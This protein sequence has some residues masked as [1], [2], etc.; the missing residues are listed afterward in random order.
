MAKEKTTYLSIWSNLG[1]RFLNIQK[2]IFKMNSE[3]T[4][5]IR[6]SS[7]YENAAVGF[8]G[9]DFLNACFSVSTQLAPEALLDKI[10]KIENEFG[11][12]RSPNAGYVSRP[13]DLDILY[14]KDKVVATEHLKVPHPRMTERNFVLKPLAD[15]APQY[16]H[17]VLKKDTRNLLQQC[18]DGNPLNKTK[19][20]LHTSRESLYG[21][22]QFLSIE[23]NIGAGKTTLTKMIAEDFN[24]K[25]V[26]ERFADNPFLPK[27]Y[28]DQSRYAFPLEMSFLAD[29]YQQFTDDTSQFDLFKKFMVSDYDIF[30]SLIFAKV[31]LQKEEFSLYKKVFN[32]MYKEVKKPDIYVYLYQSTQ[33]LLY[34]IKKRGRD[35]EQGI[36]A[37][38]LDKINRGYLDFIK[39]HPQ[40][41]TLMIDLA[42]LDFVANKTDYEY[43]MERIDT[44]LIET[45]CYDNF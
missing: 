14:F 24:A 12:E 21:Q 8:D 34:N 23:G 27:F 32:F 41:T 22:L 26:L 42:D 6:V 33:R 10:T 28:E 18:K 3:H 7:V 17:P 16:Y 25:L 9:E 1:N 44:K 39:S 15:I 38:Y 5:V 35:Y 30:K 4:K 45:L 29:R 31:T 13:I 20:I 19:H 36:T 37:E 43:I 2:A 11:R 40:Q